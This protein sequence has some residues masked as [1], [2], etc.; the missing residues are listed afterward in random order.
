MIEEAF[1]INLVEETIKSYLDNEPDLERKQETYIY[2]HYLIINSSG[3]LLKVT[4]KNMATNLPGVREVYIKP[5]KGASMM[6]P[7]SMGQRYAYVIASG[8]TPEEAKKNAVNATS[9]IKFYLEPL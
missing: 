1:G 3:K 8:D 9:H 5:R 7:I 2:T 6:P 4:G